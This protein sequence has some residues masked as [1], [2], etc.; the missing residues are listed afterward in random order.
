MRND[1][2]GNEKKVMNK[3]QIQ[4]ILN[5]SIVS[6]YVIQSRIG[7]TSKIEVGNKFMQSV[8]QLP[9]QIIL[10]VSSVT[11]CVS[12]RNGC[13]FIQDSGLYDTTH[14]RACACAHTHTHTHTHTHM[15]QYHSQLT[16]FR[17]LNDLKLMLCLFLRKI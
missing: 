17:Q 4:R 8:E 11:Q 7:V 15:E 5:M 10:K 14:T 12:Q 1:K 16:R 2:K 9:I 6:L 3:V 13:C